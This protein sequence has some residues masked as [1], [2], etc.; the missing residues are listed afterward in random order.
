MVK[1]IFSRTTF[2]PKLFDIWD[3]RSMDN[4]RNL[5]RK[6]GGENPRP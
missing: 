6:A 2:N 4:L 5:K 3:T 1:F